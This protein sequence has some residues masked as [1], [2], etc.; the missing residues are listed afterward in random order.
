MNDLYTVL[1]PLQMD[2][3]DYEPGEAVEIA[4][5]ALAERLV[6]KGVVEPAGETAEEGEA[7]E[8]SEADGAERLH[9]LV[10]AAAG[11]PASDKEKW[12]RGGKPTTEALSQALV[13]ATGDARDVSAQERDRVWDLV[14]VC[15]AEPEARAEAAEARADAAEARADAAEAR[16]DAAEARAEAAEAAAKQPK[17]PKQPKKD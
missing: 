11:F 16:A 2:L 15:R 1:T 13:R 5:P 4:D 7:S 8:R 12:T 3:R 9:A 10:T 6:A 14:E 17:E